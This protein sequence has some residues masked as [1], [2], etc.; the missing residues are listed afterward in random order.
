MAFL[1]LLKA[2]DPE[3]NLVAKFYQCRHM[4]CRYRFKKLF[5]PV[6]NEQEEVEV[7]VAGSHSHQVMVT[8]IGDEAHVFTSEKRQSSKK[9]NVSKSSEGESMLDRQIMERDPEPPLSYISESFPTES[10]PSINQQHAICQEIERLQIREAEIK[11]LLAEKRLD[12]VS[13]HKTVNELDC[14]IA[15]CEA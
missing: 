6:E 5:R 1:K 9:R 12:W 7:T 2:V 3:T 10:K 15:K 14:Q 11:Q 13:K 4:G 8:A